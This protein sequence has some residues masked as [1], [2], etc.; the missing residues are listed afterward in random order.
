MYVCNFFASTGQRI[1][2][3]E[4]LGSLLRGNVKRKDTEGVAHLARASDH[5]QRRKTVA[6]RISA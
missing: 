3:E 6:A 5:K 2:R 1:F 4:N